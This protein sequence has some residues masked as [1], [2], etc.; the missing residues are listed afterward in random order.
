MS[1]LKNA[2]RAIIIARVSSESQG[3][4]DHHSIPGQLRNLEDYVKRGGK[5]GTLSDKGIERHELRESAFQGTRPEFAK[6]IENLDENE[7]VA[8]IF[9]D[10]DRFSRQVRSKLLV[11]LDKLRKEG[12]IELHFVTSNLAVTQ[13]SSANEI[14]VWNI[15]MAVAEG[16]SKMIS[17]KVKKGNREKLEKGEFIG[18]CPTGYLNV[19]T[20]IDE[21]RF[22]REIKIDESKVEFIKKCFRLYSTG[23]YV[24]SELVE[25]MQKAGF[26]IKS[27]KIRNGENELEEKT[28][29]RKAGR[30][31]IHAILKNPFY[32]GKFYREDPDTGER[33]LFPRSGLATNYVP[34]IDK[35]LFDLVQTVLAGKNTRINGYTK[36]NF[37]FRGLLKCSFCDSAIT[38]EEMSRTYGKKSKGKNINQV[39]YHCS[40]GHTMSDP[41]YYEKKFGKDHSGVYISKKGKRKGE[42]VIACPQRWW[43]EEEIEA[44]ILAEFDMLHYDD[45]VYEIL[46]KGLAMNYEEQITMTNKEIKGLKIRYGKNEKLISALVDKYALEKDKKFAEG[47]KKRCDDV[48]KVQENLRDEMR[49]Y[50]EAKELDTDKILDSMKLCCNLREHYESLDSKKQRELLSMCFDKIAATKGKWRLNGNG[51]KVEVEAQI[52]PVFSEA[53]AFLKKLKID[54]ILPAHDEKHRNI[55]LTNVTDLKTCLVSFSVLHKFLKIFQYQNLGAKFRKLGLSVAG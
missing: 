24:V 35:S 53:F 21:N 32:Y 4:D 14:M 42:K 1:K 18:Y 9:D 33:A 37:K 3:T 38:P 40:N 55:K 10:I 6:I 2:L 28:A 47:I 13:N 44:L 5:F 39:Y 12:K 49:I 50:E 48:G 19:K 20:K 15:L 43:K 7:T 30:N 8:L 36:N 51:R 41:N 16:Q 34:L 54:E 22:K 23:R 25:I 26:A 11:N 31:D 29:E 27:K 17:E 52:Y 45:N 46:K